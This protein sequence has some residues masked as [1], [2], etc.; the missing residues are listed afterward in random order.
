MI[1]AGLCCLLFALLAGSGV[2]W[3][4]WGW[5][6]EQ[7]VISQL[8]A[9]DV[10]VRRK[11][12]GPEW[13]WRFY[14]G[15]LRDVAM[16]VD[17]IDYGRGPMDEDVDLT[18]LKQLKTVFLRDQKVTDKMIARLA[19]VLSL[20]VLIM[21]W[22]PIDDASLAKLSSLKNLWFLDIKGS[23]VTDAGMVHLAGMTKMRRLDL[24]GTAVTDKGLEQL[25]GM[26]QLELLGVPRDGVSERERGR[27]KSVAPNIRFGGLGGF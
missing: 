26:T 12:F 9:Q 24:S 19:G 14:R 16:R 5:R 22:A 2:A 10:S 18:P 7:A 13:C 15:P 4:W 25:H 23:N 6:A 11:P 8:T 20:E 27:L 17:L 3:L 1:R 21:D